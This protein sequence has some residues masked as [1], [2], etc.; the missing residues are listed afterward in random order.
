MVKLQPRIR[1]AA[2]LALVSC[3]V[4]VLV[5]CLNSG[6][7]DK[8]SCD[9]NDDVPRRKSKPNLL[10][11]FTLAPFAS[12]SPAQRIPVFQDAS[13][14]S[15]IQVIQ[16]DHLGY[17]V[18]KYER[19]CVTPNETILFSTTESQAQSLES[20]YSKCFKK[21]RITLSP[22]DRKFCEC[23]TVN[24]GFKFVAQR[25]TDPVIQFDPAPTYLIY[26]WLPHHHLSHFAFSTVHFHSTVQH[27]VFYGITGLKR[28]VFQDLPP[29]FTPYEQ[30]IWDIIRH[31][32]KL[33]A[34]RDVQFL[35]ER[36]G[37]P[38]CY[39]E[40]YSSKQSEIY[41]HTPRD[42]D[43]FK[44]SA[45]EVLD[46][47]L[48]SNPCPPSRTLLLVR[49]NGTIKGH[50]MRTMMNQWHV[51]RLLEAKG[52]TQIDVQDMNATLSL[53]QQAA[54]MSSYGLIISSHSSQLTNLLFAHRNA[55]VMEV[56]VIYKPAFRNLGVMSRTH[57][58]NSVGH[59][60][61]K[62]GYSYR[63]LYPRLERECNFTRMAEGDVK[64]CPM[65]V[66]EVEAMKNSDYRVHLERFER[67]LEEAVGFLEGKCWRR[68]GWVL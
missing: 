20:K 25:S 48:T 13:V 44:Q 30:G 67:D 24:V 2:S 6:W 28:I 34:I 18:C 39:Q 58:I 12:E 27:A 41:A 19:V 9:S 63:G 10:S 53:Q 21:Q 11:S 51:L 42:L 47:D 57:Y 36:E 33:E 49:T 56:S 7:R 8:R 65:S 38:Q 16:N 3:C 62:V 17:N 40:M 35:T 60:P 26:N 4:Y 55:V 43:V 61:D 32:G 54:M 15:Q 5:V 14:L 68:A 37:V 66:K 52:I 22:L 23:F 46:L 29:G 64:A 31:G 45:E 1:K 59:K 50:R